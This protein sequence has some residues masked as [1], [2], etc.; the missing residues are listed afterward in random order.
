VD[1]RGIAPKNPWLAWALHL[2]RTMAEAR[3]FPEIVRRDLNR[4]LAMLLAEHRDG[5]L[6]RSSD[7]YDVLRDQSVSIKH[8]SEILQKMGVLLDDRPTGFEKWLAAKVEG[9]APGI[10]S[11]TE[12]WART[13]HDGS[14]RSRPR[15][16]GTIT[17]YVKYARPVLLEW[18]ERHSH[19]REITREDILAHANTQHGTHRRNMLVAIRSL[20]AWAQK[21]GVIFRNPA[22]QIKVGPQDKPVWQPLPRNEIART[23]KAATTPQGPLFVALAAVHAGRSKAI[24]AMQLDD[25]DL[26]NRRLTLAGHTRPLD[27]LTHQVLLQWLDYRRERWPNTANKHLLINAKTAV[28]L[29]PVSHACPNDILRGLTASVERLRIDR[30]LEE[31]LT[32]RADPL[33]LAAVFDLDTTTAIRYATSARQLLEQPHETLS[34]SPPPTQVHIS[35]NNPIKDLSSR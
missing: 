27:D 30:Q 34:S 23:I 22:S 32:H 3:G 15:A 24:R 16:R 25:I 19:L 13:L 4:T 21:N 33:H 6:I 2:A 29:G 26:P 1:P 10:R 14:P 5:E 31:A 11:E 35:D 28:G 7:F 9:L 12:R 20:F 8:T 17:T 18:S